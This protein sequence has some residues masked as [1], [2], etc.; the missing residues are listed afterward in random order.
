[1]LLETFETIWGDV[2]VG[3]YCCGTCPDGCVGDVVRYRV[4]KRATVKKGYWADHGFMGLCDAAAAKDTFS[5]YLLLTVEEWDDWRRNH[6]Y[7][8]VGG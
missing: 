8:P 3:S 5:G 2:V 1:M 6:L 4:L 7:F